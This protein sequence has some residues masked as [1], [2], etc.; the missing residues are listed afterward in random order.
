MELVVPV[1]PDNTAGHKTTIVPQDK[2]LLWPRKGGEDQM[3]WKDKGVS[4]NKA[5]AVVFLFTVK[6]LVQCFSRRHDF[7]SLMKHF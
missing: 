4:K 2:V 6:S 1:E 5:F 7:T 3:L